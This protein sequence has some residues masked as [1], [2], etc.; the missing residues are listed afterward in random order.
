MDEPEEIRF[1]LV[2]EKKGE[3]FMI[4][5]LNKGISDGELTIIFEELSIAAKKRFKKLL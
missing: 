2:I 1:S 5:S 4:S 3:Y